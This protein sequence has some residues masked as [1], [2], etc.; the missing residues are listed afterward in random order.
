MLLALNIITIYLIFS[1]RVHTITVEKPS[2]TTFENLYNRYTSALQCPCSRI[3]NSYQ[4]FTSLSPVFHPVCSSLYISDAWI[5]SISGLNINDSVYDAIDFRT[6][7]PTFFRTLAT[8]CSLSNITIYN[9]WYIFSQTPLIT[10][11][12]LIESEFKARTK[13]VIEQFQKKTIS[14]FQRVLSLVELHTRTMY[15]TGYL[16]IVL[17]TN[18]LSTTTTP[19]DF[20]W[21]PVATNTCSCDLSDRCDDAMSFYSYTDNTIYAPYNLTFT[22]PDILIGCFVVS[23]VLRSSLAC[24]FNQTCLDIVQHEIKSERSIN[25]SILD[26]NSTRF[27]PQSL[28]RTVLDNLMIETWNEKI[29][30]DEYYEQCAPEQ[31]TYTYTS[32]PNALQIITT[33]VGLF[34]GLSVVLKVAVPFIIRWIRN[35]IDSYEQP[36]TLKGKTG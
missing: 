33:V 1:V 28:I 4:L 27:S 10:D 19:I 6:A 35:R 11:F 29:E 8:L 14:E 31:C 36:K 5:I 23:S 21:K 15:G 30:Y 22:L 18:Q 32:S 2:Q 12:T 13:V 26:I 25:I 24:F 9:A 3:A 17:Y 7:G 16:N 20:G 34:G